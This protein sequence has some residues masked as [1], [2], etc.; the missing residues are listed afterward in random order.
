ML[1]RC[2]P[3]SVKTLINGIVILAS[4]F[5]CGQRVTKDRVSQENNS[6]RVK[7]LYFDNAFSL[8]SSSQLRLDGYYLVRQIFG[9]FTTNGKD[10]RPH[11]PTYGYL[12][13]FNDGFCKVG[14]WNGFFNSP[15]EIE[16]HMLKNDAFGFWGIYKVHSDT[17]ELEYLYNPSSPGVPPFEERNT[18]VGLI[19][20]NE[21]IIT[22]HANIK[23]SFPKVPKDSLSSSCIGTFVSVPTDYLKMDNYLKK[24]TS[25]Y[26]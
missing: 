18:L 10:Y 6:A 1:G 19:K 23:Y 11:D 21:I 14:W 5:S 16:N 8:D 15:S 20:Q 4:L 22:E 3:F 25:Y 2:M 12:Q 17:L 13:F 26:K 24:D 9:T 7:L